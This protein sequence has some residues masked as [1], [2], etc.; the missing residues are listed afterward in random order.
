MRNDRENLAKWLK[1]S[2][3]IKFGN[4][5]WNGVGVDDDHPVRK[6]ENDD[7]KVNDLVTYLLGQI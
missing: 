3:E 7:Q 1:N 4:L 6:L 2:N 5:M